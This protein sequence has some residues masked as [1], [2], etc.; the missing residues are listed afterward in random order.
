MQNYGLTHHTIMNFLSIQSWGFVACIVRLVETLRDAIVAILLL[1]YNTL[2]KIILETV[3]IEIFC[4]STVKCCRHWH[5]F[6]HHCRLICNILRRSVGFVQ[7]L[8][9]NPT[10]MYQTMETYD[11]VRALQWMRNIPWSCNFEVTLYCAEKTLS[12]VWF[13]FSETVLHTSDY[14]DTNGRM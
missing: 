9:K 7:C 3:N 12:Y 11:K 8:S 6:H 4:L 2:Q 5:A 13:F 14:T 1:L 10:A